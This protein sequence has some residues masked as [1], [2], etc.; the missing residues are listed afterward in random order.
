MMV[1]ELLSPLR[2]RVCGVVEDMISSWQ[3]V[4][5]QL[6]AGSE[7]NARIAQRT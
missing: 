6:A 1:F 2:C 7:L 4:E 5:A 3:L